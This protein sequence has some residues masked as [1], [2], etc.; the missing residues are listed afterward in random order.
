MQV[1]VH[2]ERSAGTCRQSRCYPT[3]LL[4]KLLPPLLI[5][6]WTLLT[7]QPLG[8]N[9]NTNLFCNVN[10]SQ[11]LIRQIA[12]YTV[13]LQVDQAQ[14]CV[15]VITD[16]KSKREVFTISDQNMNLD[17]HSGERISGGESP[18]VVLFSYPEA[19]R[20]SFLYTIASLG[21]RFEVLKEI[22]NSDFVDFKSLEKN[23]PIYLIT[24]D[25]K[26]DA[27]LKNELHTDFYYVIKPDVILRLDDRKLLNAST[28]FA[29]TYD[30][31]TTAVR[32]ALTAHDIAQ[33]LKAPALEKNDGIKATILGLL[34][35]YLYSGREQQAWQA[36]HEMWPADDQERLKK[37][38]LAVYHTG[39]LAQ[40][41]G[42]DRCD[43]QH[44]PK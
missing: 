37:A 18:D 28:C 43:E 38:L 3:E 17:R 5:S 32:E 29:R 6:V 36:L 16:N 11:P 2:A 33:F 23:G 13:R 14:R 1:E 21:K 9:E 10:T 4:R 12:G 27:F 39:I 44:S 40:T 34:L 42:R 24:H 22:T 19:G 26:L 41:D 7:P 15:A 20:E 8:A 35:N 31:Q 25:G 30:A